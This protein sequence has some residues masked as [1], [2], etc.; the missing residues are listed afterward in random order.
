MQTESPLLEEEFLTLLCK[1]PLNLTEGRV[2]WEKRKHDCINCVSIQT[3]KESC[4][5]KNTKNKNY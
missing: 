2:A 5:L 3:K 1:Y 4:I